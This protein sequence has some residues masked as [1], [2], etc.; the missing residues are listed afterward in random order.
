MSSRP[1]S[2]V[3][4]VRRALDHFFG[5]ICYPPYHIFAV[6]D[7]SVVL[8]CDLIPSNHQKCRVLLVRLALTHV[9]ARVINRH[10]QG[11]KQSVQ[12]SH[13]VQN[14]AIII[15]TPVSF[16]KVVIVRYFKWKIYQQHDKSLGVDQEDV[17][18]FILYTNNK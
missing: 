5:R 1:S 18:F 10:S 8:T 11:V 14:N 4:Q 12:E 7:A 16:S 15:M 6:P 17:F 2:P 13:A 3:R 9:V